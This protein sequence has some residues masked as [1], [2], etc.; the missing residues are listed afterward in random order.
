MTNLR[1]RITSSIRNQRQMPACSLRQTAPWLT[2]IGLFVAWPLQAQSGGD[3]RAL[4]P[5][6][7]A[8]TNINITPKRIAF[9]RGQR[10]ATVYVFNQGTAPATVDIS[11]VDRIMLPNGQIEP[12]SSNAKE[13]DKLRSAKD[14]LLATPR[15]AIVAPGRGQTIRL[16]LKSP[17]PDALEHR[18][19]LTVTTVPPREFGVTPDEAAA[20]PKGDRLSFQIASVFGISIPVIVR[21]GSPDV[22]ATISGVELR[23]V[24]SAPDSSLKRVAVLA[25]NL[26]RSGANSLYGNI[27]ITGVKTKSRYALARGIGV[28]TEIASRRVELPLQRMPASKEQLQIKFVDDDVAPGHVIA[29]SSFAVD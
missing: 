2:V 17:P 28:Y 25:F 3:P 21:W 22:R 16:R 23:Y 19:H 8:R 29:T 5:D 12:L 6:I 10:A 1:L 11:L 4:R 26:H 18:T 7:E 14:L 20:G 15:R 13:A 27:E 9:E 24:N